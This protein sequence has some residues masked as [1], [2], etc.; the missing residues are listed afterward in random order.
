M[1]PLLRV[2]AAPALFAAI[3][4]TARWS[5]SQALANVECD[6]WRHAAGETACDRE[7]WLGLLLRG[8]GWWVLLAAALSGTLLARKL[9]TAVR[10]RKPAVST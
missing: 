3:P 9:W 5:L 2:L 4:L 10:R 6:G 1:R 7:G 8:A